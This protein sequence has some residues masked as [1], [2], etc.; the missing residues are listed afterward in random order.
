M[1]AMIS[2]KFQQVQAYCAEHNVQKVQAGPNQICPECA[3]NLVNK[4]NQ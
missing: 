1:N 4:N 3:K 2:M